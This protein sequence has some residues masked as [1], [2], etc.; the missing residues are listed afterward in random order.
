MRWLSANW[1]WLVVI[2]GM[3]WMH[4]ACTGAT[5]ATAATGPSRATGPT[6]TTAASRREPLAAP[7]VGATAIVD[8]EAWAPPAW[9]RPVRVDRSA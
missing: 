8:A 2:G 7:R 3:L 4:W 5:E 9:R 1:V 6:T